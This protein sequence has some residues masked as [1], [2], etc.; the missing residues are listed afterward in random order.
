[1]DTVH[2]ELYNCLFWATLSI[3][4]LVFLPIHIPQYP[5]LPLSSSHTP[6]QS[7]TPKINLKDREDTVKSYNFPSLIMSSSP[8]C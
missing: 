5:N 1:M 7:H 6:I 2:M 4:S 8:G 3:S